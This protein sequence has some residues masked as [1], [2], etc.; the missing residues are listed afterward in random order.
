[1]CRSRDFSERMKCYQSDKS[2][3]VAEQIGEN[4]PGKSK[5]IFIKMKK[6]SP[7]FSSFGWRQTHRKFACFS[8]FGHMI[9]EE[10]ISQSFILS[11]Q[12]FAREIHRTD[13][14]SFVKI[15]GLRLSSFELF[16]VEK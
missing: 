5:D 12:C 16:N 3:D 11:F 9:N 15:C 1:M 13:E 7:K 4:S 14:E 8:L 2:R 10:K 6:W